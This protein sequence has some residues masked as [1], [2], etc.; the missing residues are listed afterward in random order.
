MKTSLQQSLFVKSVFGI[1]ES[2]ET[3]QY[4]L[5]TR[6]AESWSALSVRGLLCLGIIVHKLFLVTLYFDREG[7]SSKKLD[8]L[9]FASALF[10]NFESNRATEPLQSKVAV[11][12]IA[13]DFKRSTMKKVCEFERHGQDNTVRRFFFSEDSSLGSIFILRLA[14]NLHFDNGTSQHTSKAAHKFKF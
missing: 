3:K 4:K 11:R 6:R 2:S 14:S 12:F 13:F 5:H 9:R 10:R 1:T 7:R 8:L